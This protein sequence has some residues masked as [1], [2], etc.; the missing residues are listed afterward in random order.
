MAICN[1]AFDGKFQW[2][3][4]IVDILRILEHVLRLEIAR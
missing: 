4:A 3:I 1:D 2:D